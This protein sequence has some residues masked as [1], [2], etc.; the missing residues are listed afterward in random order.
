MKT[1][2]IGGGNSHNFIDMDMVERRHIPTV[3]F[4]DFLAEV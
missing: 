2:L 3:D 1:I 4:E